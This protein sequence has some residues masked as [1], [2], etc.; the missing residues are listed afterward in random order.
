[1]TKT[2]REYFNSLKFL[3]ANSELENTEIEDLTTFLNKMIDE[4]DKKTENSKKYAKKR[5]AA[6]GDTLAG[7]IF[8]AL[9]NY[10][11]GANILQL[12]SDLGGAATQQKVVYR[13][14]SMAKSGLVQK[15]QMTIKEDG[16]SRKVNKYTLAV[17]ETETE[18]EVI[19]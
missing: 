2:K 9:K 11:D 1:M 13:L 3:V 14:N 6:A 8:D 4:L 19:E 17:T 15:S 5:T 10:P 16:K 12:V 18:T 7:D